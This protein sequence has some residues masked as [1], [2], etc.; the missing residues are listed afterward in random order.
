[1][2]KED[3]EIPKG[4]KVVNSDAHDLYLGERCVC[5]TG[6]LVV[7]DEKGIVGTAKSEEEGRK[8]ATI[9]DALGLGEATWSNIVD[10]LYESVTRD[11]RVR[12]FGSHGDS[13]GFNR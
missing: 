11:K 3:Y 12:R 7:H 2:A 5:S 6:F 1:M 9:V 8:L 13:R 10:S 4:Y